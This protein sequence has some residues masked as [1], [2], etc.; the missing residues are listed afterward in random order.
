M[1][2]VDIV[3]VNWNTGEA[4]RECL[5]GL[6]Q[7]SCAFAEVASVTV[8]DN[9]SSDGSDRLD[10]CRLPLR[11]LRNDENRGFA[12]A[13]NQGARTGGAPFV[14]FLNPDVV[15]TPTTLVETLDF[16]EQPANGSIGICGV[17]LTDDAGRPG[18][19]WSRVPTV[20]MFLSEMVGADWLL[21]RR[22]RARLMSGADAPKDGIVDQVIGAYFLVRRDLFQALGG[23]DERFFVYYEELDFSLRASELGWRSACLKWVSA[24]H[25][26]GVSSAKARH[27]RLFYSLRSRHLYTRK[28]FSPWQHVIVTTA[29]LA[30]EVP[31]RMGRALRRRSLVELRETVAAAGLFLQYLRRAP[32]AGSSRH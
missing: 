18:L 27:N 17:S 26:G 3:I 25:S 24:R 20:A 10:D 11:L 8:V 29:T 31:A 21:R 23:F 14:L 5:T 22:G 16:L 19:S 32:V 28:H 12:A 15:V 1:P 6:A 13:C 4:L 7:S 9:A 30:V 2:S